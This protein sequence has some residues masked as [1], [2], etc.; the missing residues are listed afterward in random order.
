MIQD[1]NEIL[2]HRLRGFDNFEY[3]EKAIKKAVKSNVLYLE[4]DTRVTK[5]KVIYVY[6]DAIYTTIDNKK[7]N[8]TKVNSDTINKNIHSNG[9]QLLTLDRLLE[10]FA[11]RLN[12]NQKLCIDIKDYGFEKEH[13][14]LV[15]KYNL[16][17]NI[18][19]VSWI[20]QT[21]SSLHML[22]PNSPKVLSFMPLHK[23][24]FLGDILEKISIIKIPFINIVAMGKKY[25]D[26]N[27]SKRS[28]AIGFQHVYLAKEL[29][30]ELLNILKESNG[31]LCI[32]KE[33]FT[34]EIKKYTK[35]HNLTLL[36]FSIN[37]KE[38]Y[39]KYSKYKVNILFADSL[40]FD[41]SNTPNSHHDN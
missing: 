23:F 36:L 17:N 31:G 41:K 4:I 9:H 22:T 29:S 20:P 19:W 13:L 7:I 16:T 27:L 10:I 12:K 28:L 30:I 35:Q 6:H 37:S 2:S 33:F 26:I 15:Q 14:R 1:I 25:F 21:L 39:K 18:I 38:E 11:T 5:N 3:T 24:Y 8:I 32:Q 40:I 34:E